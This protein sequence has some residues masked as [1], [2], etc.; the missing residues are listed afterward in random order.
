MT[1]NGN[2]KSTPRDVIKRKGRTAPLITQK[3]YAMTSKE[4]EVCAKRASQELEKARRELLLL[5]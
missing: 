3:G 4:A 2:S 5:K 1:N